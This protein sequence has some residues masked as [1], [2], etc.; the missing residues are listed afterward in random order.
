MKYPLQIACCFVGT[1]IAYNVRF[2]ATA[3]HSI[4]LAE[5]EAQHRN[6]QT[7]ESGAIFSPD[8]EFIQGIE[9]GKDRI[10]APKSYRRR[11]RGGIVVHNHPGDFD[12][13]FS[14]GDWGYAAQTEVL[15]MRV[16]TA[17]STYTLRCDWDAQWWEDEG[18]P[19]LEAIAQSLKPHHQQWIVDLQ[20]Q[21]YAEEK[22][23]QIANSE[24]WHQLNQQG[25]DALGCDYTRLE[26]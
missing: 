1:A 5:W 7:H 18:K 9:G 8:G 22:A 24:Y 4:T 21:G 25:A 17:W 23:K 3:Q 26:G 10:D 11:S 6:Q 12:G 15:E 2:P 19:T 16:V 20:H 14:L 13:S